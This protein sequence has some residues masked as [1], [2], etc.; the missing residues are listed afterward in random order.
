MTAHTRVAPL[1]A[2]RLAALR[3]QIF[4]PTGAPGVYARSG[5]YETVVEAL[6]RLI[7]AQRPTGAEVWRFPPVMSRSQIERHGYLKSFPHLLGAVSCL[8]GDERHVRGV[9]QRF[10]DE[11]EPWTD[12]LAAS[13]LVLAPAACYPVYPLAAARGPVSAEGL[14]FDVAADCFRREPS[15]DIDRL[16]SFR[17]REFVRVGT[18]D[19]VAEFRAQWIEKATALAGRL[20]LAWRIE[21]ANDPFFGRGGQIAAASQREQALKF[22]LLAPIRSLEDPTACV[23]FNY[24]QDHFGLTWDLRLEDGSPAHTACIA[25]GIDRLAV[26]LFAAHGTESSGWPS[27]VGRALDL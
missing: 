3:D 13:D 25:F 10:C 8:C 20:G 4:Q 18:A 6:A 24:H 26:A 19:Q 1:D 2:A 17:M 12:Q 15:D 7:S 21:L 23:S 14:V 9:V 27:A 5:R 22:E 16:Q 11:G